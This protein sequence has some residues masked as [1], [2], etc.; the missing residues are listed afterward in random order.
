MERVRTAVIGAGSMGGLHLRCLAQILEAQVVAVVDPHLPAA[1]KAAEAEGVRAFA[2]VADMLSA[3]APQYVVVAS[4]PRFHAEQCIAAFQAGAHVLCE[5]P[6]CMSVAEAEA[7]AAAATSAQRRFTMGLQIRQSPVEQAVH[8][9]I[10]DGHLGQVYHTRV[11]G[12]HNMHYPGGRFFHR[13]DM[14]LGGVI[15]ATTVHHIDAV[16]WLIGAPRPLTVS[17]STFRRIDR[18]PDP[19]IHFEG[20][21]SEVTVEDF[22]HA[23]ARFADGS[24][25]SI[26]GNW[27][28][29][30]R[31]RNWGWEIHGTLGVVQSVEPYVALDRQQEVTPVDLVIGEEPENRTQAEHVAFI[32]VIRGRSST[33]VTWDE[34]I[35]V[36]RLVNGI[37]ESAEA[38]AEVRL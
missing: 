10:A 8:E 16:Y 23:H 21:V 2:D 12:G 7:M 15:A 6:L 13:A 27:L 1:E 24:S 9:Y 37:Y 4:P 25:M 20:D 30:P 29:H 31:E 19:P 22:S 34:A 18:M 3:V 5:K 28:Q 33:V 26:E 14:S 32:D 17:A 36:Q 35:S 11:W 38:G